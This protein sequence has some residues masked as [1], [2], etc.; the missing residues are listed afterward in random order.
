MKID[1]LGLQ[2]ASMIQ[3]Q[4][5]NDDTKWYKVKLIGYQ[6]GFGL[7]ISA[8]RSSGSELSMILRDG[9]P[10]NVRLKTAKY[11]V[12]FRTQIIEKRL[13]PY[14][15]IHITVPNTLE[16]VKPLKAEMMK[17]KEDATLINEDNDSHSA[18]V[19]VVGISFTEVK[20]KHSDTIA[21]EDQRVTITMSFAFAGKRNVI[22]LEGRVTKVE[23]EPVSKENLYIISYDE[24]DQADQIL[25]HAY[26]YERML[27][28]LNILAE[29]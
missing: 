13:T 5:L 16:N 2:I 10:L 24:L 12:S 19:D 7:L 8:P 14:P 27:I 28:N 9:Q 6:K 26:I 11:A 1:Q 29:Q 21:R 17:L 25:L 4:M 3:I 22:V 23:I 18:Q 15:H 20:V